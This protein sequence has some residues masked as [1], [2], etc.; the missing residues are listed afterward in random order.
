MWGIGLLLSEFECWL[1][2]MVL[3]YL[4]LIRGWFMEI[5]CNVMNGYI[6]IFG[7]EM[8]CLGILEC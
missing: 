4:V 1:N 7:V 2:V 3:Y 8:I 6:E 5:G